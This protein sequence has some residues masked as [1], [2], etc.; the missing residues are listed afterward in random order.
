MPRTPASRRTAHRLAAD[1]GLLVVA[2]A[3]ALPL[4][5]VVLS[6]LDA[7]AGLEVKVP[8]GLTLDNFDAVLK[9]DITFTPLLNSLILCGGATL[10]TVACAA[11]AAY[12]L[13]R[14]RSRLNRP[15]LLTILFAT[16]LPITAVMVPVYALFVQVN[17][18][19]TLQGTIFF[20]AAS[21]LPFAIWL[22]KNFMDGVPKELEEAAWTDG[23]SSFQSLIRVVLPLMGPGVAVVTVFAF[24]MMWGN[25]FVPF[26]LLLTPDQMPASVSINDFFGNRGTVV[27]GQLAAFSVIYSTPVIL[28]YVLVARRLGGGFALGGAV[29]G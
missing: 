9:P 28:L 24:V 3:F 18:I 12:P 21:Q 7:H 20:F 8:D 2:A 26:M 19:D 5:W 13:S 22:M 11:L 4:A 16:S 14:F 23:A 15:F 1:A 17:L 27:Y 29:K 25:F 10:L 6:S